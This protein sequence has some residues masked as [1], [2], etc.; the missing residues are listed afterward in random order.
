MTGRLE[1]RHRSPLTWQ[2]RC[3]PRLGSALH[4]L[5]PSSWRER[6]AKHREACPVL[7]GQRP[8]KPQ[9]IDHSPTVPVKVVYDLSL[10]TEV[11]PLQTADG[12]DEDGDCHGVL[13]RVEM[14]RY[15]ARKNARL[16]GLAET[17]RQARQRT[18]LDGDW[19]EVPGAHAAQLPGLEDAAAWEAVLEAVSFERKHLK[20][21]S[22]SNWPDSFWSPACLNTLRPDSVNQL[23]EELSLV[24]PRFDAS[25]CAED[26]FRA[27]PAAVFMRQLLSDVRLAR[28]NLHGAAVALAISKSAEPE[29]ADPLR[30]L[31]LIAWEDALDCNFLKAHHCFRLGRLAIVAAKAELVVAQ[32]EYLTESHLCRQ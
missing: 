21:G 11:A 10:L 3:A 9:R 15:I 17:S 18:A 23:D 30:P 28:G 6:A 22:S 24:L 2:S 14:S 27:L 20:R 32:A 29:S 25:K 7:Q 1:L 16:A 13:C 8:P 19:H 26:S 12:D 5:P 31:L 4:A